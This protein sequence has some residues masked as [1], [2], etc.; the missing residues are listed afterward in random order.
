[1]STTG[2]T[3]RRRLAVVINALATL[4]AVLVPATASSGATAPPP[5][6]NIT[7]TE[8][9]A[10]RVAIGYYVRRPTTA[11]AVAGSCG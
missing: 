5:V 3:V 7:V 9:T 10:H 4:A 6:S 1:M 8:R 11:P 2:W